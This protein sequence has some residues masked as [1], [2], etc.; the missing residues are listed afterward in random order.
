VH[1]VGDQTKVTGISINKQYR[2]HIEHI[3]SNGNAAV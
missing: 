3:C 2:Y 1:Q